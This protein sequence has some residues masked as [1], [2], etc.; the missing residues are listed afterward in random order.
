VVLCVLGAAVLGDFLVRLLPD[1]GRMTWFGPAGD[2][3]LLYQDRAA[4]SSRAATPGSG[5]PSP[6]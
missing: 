2:D 1:V 3:W 4:T 5:A 6:C